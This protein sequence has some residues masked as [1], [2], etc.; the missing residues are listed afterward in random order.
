[1]KTRPLIGAPGVGD[2]SHRDVPHRDTAGLARVDGGGGDRAG[3]PVDIAA[4]ARRAVEGDVVDARRGGRVDAGRVAAAGRQRSGRLLRRGGQGAVAGLRHRAGEGG[5]RERDGQGRGDLTGRPDDDV[6]RSDPDAAGAQG[7]LL[8]RLGVDLEQRPTGQQVPVQARPPLGQ[9]PLAAVGLQVRAA[10]AQHLRQ[11]N[12]G[13][14][15]NDQR[16]ADGEAEPEGTGPLVNQ[17]LD[18]A[19]RDGHVRAER[20][21]AHGLSQTDAKASSRAPGTTGMAAT[22]RA[23]ATGTAVHSS[24]APTR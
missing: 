15:A 4:A 14:D 7:D 13:E 3:R 1:M 17:P 21:Q 18:A 10:L 5:G 11:G 16:Q 22:G 12:Q 8:A 20:A 23:P 19:D 9:G 6:A 2:R 24:T